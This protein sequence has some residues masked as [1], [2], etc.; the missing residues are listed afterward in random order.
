MAN[1]VIGVLQSL[2]EAQR[3][4]HELIQRGIPA[5]TIALT[6]DEKQPSSVVSGVARLAADAAST[7]VKAGVGVAA[8][9]GGLATS[10]IKLGMPKERVHS[11]TDA[12][13]RGGVVLTI[14]ADAPAVAGM[15]A[16][17]LKRHGAIE[18]QE[19]VYQPNYTGPERRVNSTPW[20]GEERRKA[21]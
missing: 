21:G 20:L 12:L 10:L 17:V 11:Y 18:V 14:D 16:D 1:V 6:S 5:E 8:A 19:T 7:A 2:S 13:G 15:A 4:V 3:A 9:A